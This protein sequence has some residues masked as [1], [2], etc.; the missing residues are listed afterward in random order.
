MW[1]SSLKKEHRAH[2]PQRAFNREPTSRA[3]DSRRWHQEQHSSSSTHERWGTVCVKDQSCLSDCCVLTPRHQI[4]GNRYP[5]WI[6]TEH[7]VQQQ[8]QHTHTFLLT[9]VTDIQKVSSSS[10]FFWLAPATIGALVT[11]T[12]YPSADA[13]VRW[14]KKGGRRH[15]HWLV[16]FFPSTPSLTGPPR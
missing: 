8:Q 11:C 5:S 3:D 4:V 2:A 7:T 10:F 15:V 1:G 14:N 16:F 12:R 6:S 9:S 13:R